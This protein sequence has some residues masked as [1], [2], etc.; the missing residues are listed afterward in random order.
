[1][2]CYECVVKNVVNVALTFIFT[3]TFPQNAS[4]KWTESRTYKHYTKQII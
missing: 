4:P 1:M 2:I 3:Q